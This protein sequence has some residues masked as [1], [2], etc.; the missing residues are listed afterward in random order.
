MEFRY[1]SNSVF[2]RVVSE[3]L[4]PIILIIIEFIFSMRIIMMYK[5]FGFTKNWIKD[6][7]DENP[8]FSFAHIYLR[9]NYIVSIIIKTA[10]LKKF[11]REGFHHQHF[12]NLLNF[13]Y[14]LQMVVYPIFF[15]EEFW[16]LNNLEMLIVLT[17]CGYVFYNGL[18]IQYIGVNLRIFAR[19]VY[20]VLIFGTVSCFIIT[21][22]AYP[23]HTVYID[24]SQVVD[25]QIFPQM[26]VFRSLYNGVLTLFELVF[27]AV[28]F[29]RPYLE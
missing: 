25:G 14:F 17:M 7:I 6:Y 16:I 13:L 21:L 29:V 26:N 28:I 18:A 23:I 11:R 22:I 4:W 8:I 9:L 1:T 19:M 24:F 3:M 5:S 12:F 27:G 2:L 15:W 20:V 10:L